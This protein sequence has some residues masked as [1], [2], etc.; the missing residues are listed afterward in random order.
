[1]ERWNRSGPERA[2][3]NSYYCFNI[4]ILLRAVSSNSNSNRTLHCFALLR[5]ALCCV[6]MQG[7]KP[8]VLDL[9]ITLWLIIPVGI[10][11]A[12]DILMS[13][14][15]LKYVTMTFYT[16]AK[17]GSLMWYAM[18]MGNSELRCVTR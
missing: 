1:M 18:R 3:A 2:R 6:A 7:V 16:I 15:S 11:T 4:V 10:A 12:G 5:L 14:L 13:N 9:S 8:R 17:S